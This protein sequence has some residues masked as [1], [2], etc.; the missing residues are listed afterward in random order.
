MSGNDAALREKLVKIA[1]DTLLMGALDC[2]EAN[3][4]ASLGDALRVCEQAMSE[5]I[6]T[7][8][9]TCY[10]SSNAKDAG[11]EAAWSDIQYARN[12]GCPVLAAF[13]GP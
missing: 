4:T 9:V 11:Q 6:R 10:R 7:D 12:L 2:V 8:A 3:K 13:G 1:E 5:L